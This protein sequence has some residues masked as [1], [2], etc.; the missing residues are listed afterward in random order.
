MGGGENKAK[1]KEDTRTK[2]ALV[3]TALLSGCHTLLEAAKM[4]RKLRPKK[5]VESC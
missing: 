1:T 5:A 2:V 3:P 4:R